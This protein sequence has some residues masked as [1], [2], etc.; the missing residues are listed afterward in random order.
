MIKASLLAALSIVSVTSFVPN[1]GGGSA[2]RRL[3]LSS[4]V[5]TSSDSWQVTL[6]EFLDV[7]TACDVRREKFTS[8]IGKV[9]EITG[10]VTA[11]VGKGDV[12]AALEMRFSKASKNLMVKKWNIIN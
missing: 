1:S 11:A 2:T 6:D 9:S 8:L 3:V 10:D 7:D 5:P 4:T 12:E